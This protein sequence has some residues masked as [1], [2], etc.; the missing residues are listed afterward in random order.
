MAEQPACCARPSWSPQLD[1]GQAGGFDYLLG[2]CAACGAYSM[3][4]FCAASSVTAY[5]SVTPA[6][7]ERMKSVPPGPERKA[8]MRRWGDVNL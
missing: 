1:L 2:R 7:V 6:D 4:V 5:E 3:N 8:L